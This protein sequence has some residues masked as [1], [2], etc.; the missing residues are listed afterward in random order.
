VRVPG[1]AR[2]VALVS[3]KRRNDCDVRHPASIR[4]RHE[5]PGSAAPAGRARNAELGEEANRAVHRRIAPAP[6]AIRDVPPQEESQ[7]TD[8]RCI[9]CRRLREM[10]L[11]FRHDRVLLRLYR[12]SLAVRREAWRIGIAGAHFRRA[13]D[14]VLRTVARPRHAQPDNVRR[15]I[16]Q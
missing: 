11:K 5:A 10:R 16:V 12:S 3:L 1:L 6:C 2:P 13:D 15:P 4:G 8:F 7:E 9:D 14:F